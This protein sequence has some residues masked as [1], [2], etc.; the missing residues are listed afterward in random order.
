MKATILD[1]VRIT[2]E[3]HKHF[4]RTG[5]LT[6]FDTIDGEHVLHFDKLT[7]N[8]YVRQTSE[9]TRVYREQVEKVSKLDLERE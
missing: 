1:Y 7:E 6:D 3:T 5:R 8:G 2:D 4:G 9:S